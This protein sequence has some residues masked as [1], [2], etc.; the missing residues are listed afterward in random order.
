MNALSDV[1]H[2][3]R[4]TG[5]FFRKANLAAPWSVACEITP[6]DIALRH[7]QPSQVVTCHFVVRGRL[8]LSVGGRS[9]VEVNTGE[10]VLLPRS[11]PHVLGSEMGMKSISALQLLRPFEQGAH[12]AI[13]HGGEGAA[14]E[15]ACG[16]LA[17]E[18]SS[19]L[20]LSVLPKLIKLEFKEEVFRRWIEALIRIAA[21]EPADGTDAYSNVVT[22][23]S[24]A[25]LAEAI[26][27]YAT[28]NGEGEWLTG[29]KDPYVGKALSLMHQRPGVAW[30]A[31]TLA[32]EVALS[33]SAFATR[34]AARVGVPPMRYLAMLRLRKAKQELREAG[35]TIVQLAHAAGYESEAAF[36]RAFKREFGLPPLRWRLEHSG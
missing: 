30:S 13:R 2:S 22:R 10:I 20:L 19:N 7:L 3:L 4:L 17:V 27:Q 35:K 1:L 34:F 8:L 36:S 21:S 28:A 33:R 15:I 11:D 26:R 5:G 18:E 9:P 23:W 32:R 31:Q 29:L 24:E 12:P 6:D 16:F 14:T 25:L